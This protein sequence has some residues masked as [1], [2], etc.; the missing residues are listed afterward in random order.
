MTDRPWDQ[1]QAHVPQDAYASD[2]A[3][4]GD[5]DVEALVEDIEET[6]MRMTGTVDEIGDRLDPA[7]IVDGAKQTVR[8]ATVGKV[9]TMTDQATQAMDDARQTAQ[10]ASGSLV[11]TIRQNPVPAALVGIGVAWLW[12][13]RATAQMSPSSG[14]GWSGSSPRD[15]SAG[16]YRGE[17]YGV[18]NY[19]NGG[20]GSGMTDRMSDRMSDVS[21]R[22]S[23]MSGDLGDRAGDAAD[24][25]RQGADEM[26]WKAQD[27]AGRTTSQAQDTVSSVIDTTSQMIEQ[28]PLA[29][30][31]VALAVGA[32][33]GLA[34]P[35]TR[36][37][38]QVL[39]STSQQLLDKAEGTATQS[40][41]QMSQSSSDRQG[42]HQESGQGQS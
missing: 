17:P 1:G 41:H 22:V 30:G 40:L 13:H 39:G 18:R 42:Q 3:A 6:R 33:I 37:E 16:S 27:M 20:S 35:A 31:A 38:R 7:N 14:D 24:Q 26:R 21:D 23:D 4:T 19:T 34:L 5:D 10:Q 11:E 2:P 29:A 15:Y 28:N 32:A 25:I 8:D 9:E 12:T 36:Q